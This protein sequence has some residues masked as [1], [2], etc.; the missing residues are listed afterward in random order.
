MRP[1]G[2][3]GAPRLRWSGYHDRSRAETK[4]QCVEPLG[5]RLMVKDFDQQAA[6]VQIHIA[7]LNDY[8]APGIPAREAVG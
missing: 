3:L 2:R 7:V 1:G 4:K 8:A 5:Q 6:E